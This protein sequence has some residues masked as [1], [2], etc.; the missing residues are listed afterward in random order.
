MS[1]S[2]QVHVSDVPPEW[3]SELH[4]SPHE[5]QTMMDQ[6][7]EKQRR[8]LSL[9]AKD[10]L[11]DREIAR[12]VGLSRGCVLRRLVRSYCW[13]RSELVRTYGARSQVNL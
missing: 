6:L 5:V 9:H 8:L 11:S 3:P 1:G 4:C 2:N 13:L 7:P 10:G 12:L